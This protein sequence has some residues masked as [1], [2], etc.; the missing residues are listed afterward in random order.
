MLAVFNWFD[1]PDV[2]DLSPWNL[3]RLWYDLWNDEAVTLTDSMEVGPRNV[4]LLKIAQ[5][6][7]SH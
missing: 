7:S 6:G 1:Q 3:P 5:Q 4:R 2:V